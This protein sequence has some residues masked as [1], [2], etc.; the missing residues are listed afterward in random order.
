[1]KHRSPL[2]TLAAVALAFVIMFIVNMTVSPPGNSS[3][4]TANPPAVP[5]TT[6]ADSP[7]PTKTAAAKN[8]NAAPG[9]GNDGP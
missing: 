6:T 1:V 3:T 7:S 8:L 5:A 4:G 9:K 2:I